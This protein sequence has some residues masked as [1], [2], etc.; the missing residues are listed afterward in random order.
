M[1]F[2]CKIKGEREKIEKYGDLKREVA[3]MWDMKKVIVKPIVTGA[4]GAVSKEL[5]KCI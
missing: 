3:A 5:D 2:S 1:L 4:L